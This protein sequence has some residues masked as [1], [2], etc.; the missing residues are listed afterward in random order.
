MF[1][2]IFPI[3][4]VRKKMYICILFL[5]H[6]PVAGNKW[7]KKDEKRKKKKKVY[8]IG[9]GYCKFFIMWALLIELN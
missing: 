4:C 1:L 2:G 7:K 3:A 6:F 9:W 8:K 5:G